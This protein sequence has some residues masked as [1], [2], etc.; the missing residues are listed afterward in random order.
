MSG[1]VSK[2]PEESPR[3]RDLREAFSD[4]NLEVYR[5][6]N[7]YGD[8]NEVSAFKDDLKPSSKEFEFVEKYIADCTCEYV[9]KRK[10][11][12]RAIYD[13]I[14]GMTD[15]YATNEYRKLLC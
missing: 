15:S 10:I 12:Y 8:K 13:F 4:A 14:S 6:K 7:T 3:V 2:N 9:E 1:N 5:D 11:L